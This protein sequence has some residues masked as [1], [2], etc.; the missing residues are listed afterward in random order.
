VSERPA[1]PVDEPDDDQLMI[2]IQSGDPR[3]FEK[4]VARYQGPLIGFF[5]RNTRDIQLAEDLTQETLLRV[6]NQSWNY[7]PVGR[8]RG[9]MYRIGRNLLIDNVRRRSHDLLLK[10]VRRGHEEDDDVLAR[11]AGDVLS[12]VEQADIREIADLVGKVL[13][14]I[15]DEQRQ[16][17]TLHHFAGLTL[18]EIADAMEVPTATAKS[19]LRLARERLRNRLRHRGVIHLRDAEQRP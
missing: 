15:P 5:Q 4:L 2:G 17:F 10:A 11:I 12:P 9:W 13:A 18:A 7:L 16:T 8:F 1:Q 6:Y 14:E 19:R 3:A